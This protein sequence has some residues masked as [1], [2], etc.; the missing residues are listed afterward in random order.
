MFITAHRHCHFIVAD[1]IKMQTYQQ[2]YK[3]NTF[4]TILSRSEA[5]EGSLVW[6]AGG[7]RSKGC[8]AGRVG[9]D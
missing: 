2:I 1:R 7:R 8:G 3:R 4:S 9:G 5:E 6:G